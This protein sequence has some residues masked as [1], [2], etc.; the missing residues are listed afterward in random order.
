MGDIMRPVPFEALLTRIFDEYQNHR[1]IFGIPEQQFYSP[2]SPNR[3]TVFGESCATPVG[4]A[5]GPHTQLA[6]NIIT[7]WLTG[8]R[9]IELKTVQILDRLELEKPCI[10]A[11]DECF[12]TEWS[13]EFTLK[14]AAD[15]YLKA[16]FILHLLE[17]IFPLTPMQSGKSFI[18]N[19]SVGYNLDGIKQ[20]PMQQFINTMMNASKQPEFSLYRDILDRWLHDERFLLRFPGDDIRPRLDTLAHRIPATL[21]HSVTLSTMHGCPPDEI[22]AI[23]RYMLEE[24]NL[25]TFVKLN[26]TLLGYPRVREILDTC[27]FGYIALNE[28]SFDHDLK[29]DRALAMLERLM[30]LAKEKHLGFGVKLT[31][32]LGTVNNKG[33]LPGDEM[34]MSGRALFPLSINVAALLSRAFDGKLPISYSGGASQLNIREIFATGIHPITMAT[35]LLKPGGYLRLSECMR[36]LEQSDGW[37]MTQVDVTRLNALAEKAVSMAYTQKHW[38]PNDHIDVGEKLPLT[39]CYVAPCVTACAIKQDIPEYIRLMGEQRYADALELIYQRNALPAITGHICDHQ[40]QY[41]CTRLDYDSALHIRELKKIAL[42][43]GWEEYQQRWHKPAGSGT[44]HPVAVIGAGPAGLAAGYFLARAGHPVTLFEREAN[45]GGVVRNII[46]QFRIPAELVEHDI[47]FV[48]RHGVN[49]V[50][51]CDPHLSVEKLQQEGFHYVLVG[52]GTDKNSG[53]PLGGD[54]PNVRKS[55]QFLREYNR[56][57]N[58]KLGKHVAIIGAGN[59]A[60]DCARAALRVPGV[61]KV[62]IVYRRSQQEMPAWRE[63]YEEAVDDGVQFRFLNNPEE[64]NADGTL[65]LRVMTLGEADEKGRRRPLQ[66]A[67]TCTLQVDTLITAIGEQ[68]DRDALATMGIPLNEHGWPVVDL[69]GE[70]AKANVFLIGDVQRGPSSI[71]SAIGNAR[72]ATDTILARENILSHHGDKRWN[73][74]NPAE[75]YRRKGTIAVAMVNKDDRDAFVAQEASRC[76][77]CNYL[78]SKCVD[79]CPNRANVSIAVPGFQNRYQTLHL[80][81][82]CNECGNCAQFCPWQGK[83]YKDKITLFSLPE[84]FGNST[85]PGFLVEA[86]Q[87]H[88]RQNDRIWLLNIDEGGQFNDVPPPLTDMCRII[89]HVHLHHRYLL[90]GVEV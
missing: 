16:W 57:D 39:D 12:N 89:S 82:F 62:T 28:E 51:G 9:F 34:Y 38:K 15:E 81:A 72:R 3:L 24:K 27:G 60:M 4:P 77:E 23:C 42:E 56:G 73:N 30:Q 13:T 19:M 78:C 40:C 10:D 84:D 53:V 87:V 61:E 64:F 25:N 74:V 20:P 43:K 65:T 37:K 50:Y 45:A 54:N 47:D 22:E 32:T 71:V 66:T 35:D 52:T 31:N 88:V 18:F 90:G 69:N 86:N 44:R 46:P 59:T 55:L 80:D 21:V 41:N 48:I 68:Q 85:N 8:G 67:E 75:V 76:L 29:I 17:E 79:V 36:E 49:L 1:S 7:S 2:A 5:A 11:E 33:A 63:E 26:P 83:P 14:K 70:T 58:L 6:Q